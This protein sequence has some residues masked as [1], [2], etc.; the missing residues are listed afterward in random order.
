[1][2]RLLCV[3][4][5]ALSLVACNRLVPSSSSDD[6]KALQGTWTLV[7]AT[8]NGAPQTG[9][10]QWVVDGDEYKTRYN[11]QLDNSPVKITL[12]ASNKHIDAFHHD[13][14][15]GTYGGK[16]K[17]IYELNGNTLRICYDLTGSSYP[18]SFDAG[19]GSRRVIYEFRRE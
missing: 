15:A 11:G 14:P 10:M 5:L 12:D 18:S 6:M 9:D 3:V 4:V 16:F 17:G 8:E 2:K 13:T 1:M 19:P 7:S